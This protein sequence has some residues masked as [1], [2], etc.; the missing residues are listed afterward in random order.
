MPDVTCVGVLV[1]DVIVRPVDTWPDP[2]RLVLV[3]GIDLHS[4]GLAHTTGIALAKLGIPAAVVGRVGRD[5]F[6]TFLI[7]TLREHQ[8]EVHVGRDDTGSTSTTVVA[9]A[10]NGERSFL[11][12]PG[13][14]TRLT[15]EDVP[16]ALL[17]SSRVVHLGGYFLLP[18]LDG[19]PAAAML[20]QARTHGCRTS[21][22]VAW[23]P[24]GR[25]MGTLA[26]CLPHLDLLFGNREELARV[27]HVDDPPRMASVLRE[28]GV[29]IVAVK[30]GED[31]A[32]VDGGSW[33]GRLPAFSVD[34]VDTTGAGDAFCAGFLAGYLRGWDLEHTT[35]FA[36]AVGAMCVTSVGGSTGVRSMTET[37]RFVETTPLRP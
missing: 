24:C 17:A 5:L 1:A 34:V 21:L 23:D 15:R 30:L 4:G 2:G 29:R 8:V 37:L 16:E 7:D 22:D 31:G 32:Y 36:N 13:A 12:L 10:G 14:N 19:S 27:T 3:D 20:Q 33:R 26:P 35:R 28:L 18:A 9:V 11:H 6:G 25:W